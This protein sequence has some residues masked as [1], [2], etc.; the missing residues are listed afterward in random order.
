[1][2]MNRTRGFSIVEVLVALVVLS[3]GMLGIA[4]LYVF[5]LQSG[6]SSIF[7]TQAVNLAADMADRIRANQAATVGYA[8]DGADHD[9]ESADCTAVE[10]AEDDRAGWEGQVAAA[11]PNGEG[12]V[13]VAGAAVPFTY[14]ITVSWSEPGVEADQSYTLTVQ[15]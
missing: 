12:A 5:A 13:A 7:R 11:L 15:I 8:A 6:T 14:T 2:N 3:V 10:I 1:M 4:G 9:C